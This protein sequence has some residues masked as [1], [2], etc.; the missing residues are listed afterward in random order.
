[1]KKEI[2]KPGDRIEK[3]DA[4]SDRHYIL[5]VADN[6]LSYVKPCA[7]DGAKPIL[8][9]VWGNT[10]TGHNVMCYGHTI[11][12]S[13]DHG[14]ECYTEKDCYGC[15]GNYV[16]YP[17]NQL[18]LADNLLYFLTYGWEKMADDIISE[19]HR[20]HAE[21]FR[22]FTVGDVPS[23][24]FVRMMVKVG[25]ECPTCEFWGYTK[26]YMMVNYIIHHDFND[27]AESFHKYTGLIFSHWLNRDHVTYFPMLNP[28]HM[29]TSEFIPY[30]MESLAETMDHICPCSNPDVVEHCGNCSTP[31]YRL[32]LGQSM[33][34]LEHSTKQ[35]K[36]RDKDIR[37][38][39]ELLL[40][41]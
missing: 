8:H 23:I 40:A 41:K 10:K 12:A 19:I 37:K 17:V 14:C 6:G 35:T 26:K 36:Q 33:A 24:D 9:L 3:Y 18:F 39:H 38:A 15:T 1:M 27:D 29:P 25:Q 4:R 31:C 2:K 11:P 16:Q 5:T 34:L 22:W 32:K 13:C 30:G 7:A 21:K 20:Q 28:Y